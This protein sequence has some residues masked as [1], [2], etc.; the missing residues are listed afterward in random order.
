MI[1]DQL[2]SHLLCPDCYQFSISY[3][4]LHDVYRRQIGE[5]R[6]QLSRANYNGHC[7]E[8]LY[9]NQVLTEHR[10]TAIASDVEVK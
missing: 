3:G 9:V 1:I 6:Y 5:C 4:G 7:Y 2:A 10:C 8:L